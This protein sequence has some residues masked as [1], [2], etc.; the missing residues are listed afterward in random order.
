MANTERTGGRP[1]RTHNRRLK[2]ASYLFGVLALLVVSL[3]M[4]SIRASAIDE[5]GMNPRQ[6]YRQRLLVCGI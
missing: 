4:T 5:P 3:F 6:S 1:D 2:T